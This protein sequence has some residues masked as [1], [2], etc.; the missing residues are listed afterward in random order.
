MA[1]F[2]PSLSV[3]L[4]FKQEWTNSPSNKWE[5]T[6]SPSNK[7]EWTHSPSNKGEWTHSPSNKGEW[8]YCPLKQRRVNPLKQGEWEGKH[9]LFVNT[10]WTKSCLLYFC[11]DNSHSI[12][13]NYIYLFQFV[14]SLKATRTHS[15][16]YFFVGLLVTILQLRRVFSVCLRC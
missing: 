5:W 2:F 10:Y 6:H 12:H 9:W 3:T 11:E 4:P 7:G 15:V 1:Y 16:I 8:T 13:Y 14:L